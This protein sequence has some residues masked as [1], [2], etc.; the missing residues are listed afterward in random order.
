M[1]KLSFLTLISSITTLVCLIFLNT[2]VEVAICVDLLIQIFCMLLSFQI[3]DK[4]FRCCCQ[5]CL[6]RYDSHVQNQFEIEIR[7]IYKSG[8]EH[9]SKQQIHKK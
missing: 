5:S 2:M 1:F 8:S 3:S 6:I 7:Q 4:L 9:N